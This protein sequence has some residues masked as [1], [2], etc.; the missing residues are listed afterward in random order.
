MKPW[1]AAVTQA[2]R[3]LKVLGSGF[4]V[5]VTSASPNI[6]IRGQFRPDGPRHEIR[7]TDIA[8]K[9]DFSGIKEA[10]SLCL[11]LDQEPQTK[12]RHDSRGTH[13]SLNLFSGW[14]VLAGALERKVSDLKSSSQRRYLQHSKQFLTFGG[15]VTKEALIDWVRS[16][17][18]GSVEYR[19]RCNTLAKARECGLQI[20]KDELESIRKAGTYKLS[21]PDRVR[22]IPT[23]DEIQT[24]LDG[25]KSRPYQWIFAMI[26]TYG[27]RPHEPFYIEE[28][29]D[30]DGDI[31]VGVNTKTGLRHVFPR[32]LDWV[33]R[34][35]LRE[36]SLPQA[37]DLRSEALNIKLPTY[38]RRNPLRSGG[39]RS[40]PLDLRHAWAIRTHS[41]EKFAHVPVAHIAE[42]QG[43]SETVHRR[44]YHRW[45]GKQELKARFKSVRSLIDN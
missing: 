5:R 20:S 27:L 19:H 28:L 4:R 9:E 31:V 24:W 23:D 26:S 36:R 2:N 22:V 25:L 11:Q 13:T 29:P 1:T 33:E 32:R 15:E 8:L 16:A 38:M 40:V 3:R 43:H 6:Q 21:D 30:E 10:V 42:A 35:R 18:E 12:I 34:Y 45:I 14:A 17:G 39:K 41:D 7:T 37:S 44:I